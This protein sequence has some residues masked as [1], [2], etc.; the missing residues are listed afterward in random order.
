MLV[1][2][3]FAGKSCAADPISQAAQGDLELVGHK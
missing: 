2:Q 1:H 3:V